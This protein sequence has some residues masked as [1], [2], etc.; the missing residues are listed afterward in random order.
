[1][2]LPNK[3]LLLFSNA[4][5]AVAT[6]SLVVTGKEG[7]RTVA[8]KLRKLVEQG[9]LSME[10]GHSGSLWRLCGFDPSEYLKKQREIANIKFLSVVYLGS[11]STFSS[12]QRFSARDHVIFCY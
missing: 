4:K 1:M 12:K 6:K 5:A 9:L 11:T 2:E 8:K 3:R 7:K 10:N